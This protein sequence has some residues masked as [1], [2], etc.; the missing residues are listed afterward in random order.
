[1][2]FINYDIMAPR[3]E[4]MASL[5]END[6]IVEQEQFDLSCGKPKMHIEETGNN[7]V[8]IKCEY[9]GSG[10]KDNAFLEGTYFFGSIVQKDDRCFIRGFVVTAPIYHAVIAILLIVFIGKCIS[11]GGFSPVPIIALVFSILMY[12]N[13]FKK[14]KIIRRY[15]FRALK[16]AFKKINEIEAGKN[17][18]NY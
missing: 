17:S 13:E 10:T 11:L 15:V 14:Q 5:A 4:V 6:R 16:N 7:R 8:K 3:S 9:V 1:M 12:R 2:H 18:N